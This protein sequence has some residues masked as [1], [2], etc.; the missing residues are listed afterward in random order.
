M[1]P[2]GG[3]LVGLAARFAAEGFEPTVLER[4]TRSEIVLGCCPFVDAA[5]ANPEVVCRLHLGLA[6]GAAESMGGVQV[7]GLLPRNPHR[8]GCRVAVTV[9]E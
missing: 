7:D 3:G 1:S 4:G 8:A 9:T 5:A 2:S 6:Q